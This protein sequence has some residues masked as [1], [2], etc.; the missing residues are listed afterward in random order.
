MNIYPSQV[1]SS[2]R[3]AQVKSHTSPNGNGVHNG[4]AGKRASRSACPLCSSPTRNTVAKMASGAV[5][6]FRACSRC[7]WQGRGLPYVQRGMTQLEFAFMSA[8]MEQL[9]FGFVSKMNGRE[10]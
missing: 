10:S 8:G 2:P 1:K 5:L 6:Q 9:E 4:S 7:N 3:E